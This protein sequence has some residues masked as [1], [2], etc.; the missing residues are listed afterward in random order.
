MDQVGLIDYYNV[1]SVQRDASSEQLA[2]AY[3]KYALK[4]HPQKNEGNLVAERTFAQ[5][6]EA[7]SVLSDAKLRATYDQSGVIGLKEGVDNGQGGKSSKW[8]F[9]SNPFDLFESF[10][11]SKSPFAEFFNDDRN[12]LFVE[13][14]QSSSSGEKAEPVHVNLYCSLEELYKGAVKKVK[15]T[16]RLLKKSSRV[17]YDDTKFISVDVKAG[18]RDGTQLTFP[19]EGND[20]ANKE[21]GD[22]IFTLRETPHP[23]FRRQKDDLIY[24]TQLTLCQALTGCIIAVE[25]L[26]QRTIPVPVCKI[27]EPG[28]T[29]T[30]DDEGMPTAKDAT[31]R[32][33]LILE[34]TTEFPR[35]LSDEQRAG[36]RA[37]LGGPQ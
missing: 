31:Q 24:K 34:F 30:V 20:A 2:K 26:D 25:T 29:I 12:P 36:L 6:A 4:F 35:S 28:V 11:G 33:K 1:L 27:I 19:K 8:T 15:V 14:I 9:N 16:R 22:L 3:R 37:I 10:F 17:L 23:R 7:Y 5:V 32:G 21:Q 18:W 13:Q